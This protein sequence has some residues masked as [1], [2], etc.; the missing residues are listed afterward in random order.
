MSYPLRYLCAGV[1]L[2]AGVALIPIAWFI[3]FAAAGGGDG[4]VI[5]YSFFFPYLMFFP[6][7]PIG[8]VIST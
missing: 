5:P 1:G 8:T 6:S 4:S 3:S 2:V 7:G